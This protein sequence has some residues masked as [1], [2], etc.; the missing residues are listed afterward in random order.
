M[1]RTH[2]A[3]SMDSDQGASAG[4]A[5]K[6]AQKKVNGGPHQLLYPECDQGSH[7][8]VICTPPL[9]TLLPTARLLLRKERH[10]LREGACGPQR[11]LCGSMAAR[12]GVPPVPG[13][14]KLLVSCRVVPCTKR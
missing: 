7:L 10:A 3:V 11:A 9:C 4:A 8:R 2:S 6:T 14:H 5:A 13:K 1:S 12:L